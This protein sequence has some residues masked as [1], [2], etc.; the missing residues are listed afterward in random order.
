MDWSRA[1]TI[2]IALLLAVN[3][4]LLV[5]YIIRENDARQEELA[6]REN[7]SAILKNQGI[8][9]EAAKIPLNSLKIRNCTIK[10]AEDTEKIASR[11]LPDMT[12]SSGGDSIVYS[13]KFGNIMFL[14]E[15]F[16]LVYEAEKSVTN[17]DD[18]KDIANLIASK[19]GVSTSRTGF[20]VSGGESGYAVKIP[21][22]FAGVRIFG[23]DIELNISGGGNVIGSGKFIGQ[24]KLRRADGEGLLTSALMIKFADA[25]RGKA[26]GELTILEI[27]PGYVAKAPVGGIVSLVPTL[28]INTDKGKFYINMTDGEIIEV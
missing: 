19:L 28:M 6:I 17:A 16:S 7:V 18:A 1:K 14:K 24:G 20:E 8:N 2:I 27:S 4:F 22:I 25:V 10:S 12:L 11:L 3:A 5:T 23:S 21:Q 26:L 15:S 13:G 9:V